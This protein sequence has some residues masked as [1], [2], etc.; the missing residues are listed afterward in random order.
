MGALTII[1]MPV[2]II[3]GKYAFRAL[4]DYT[5]QRKQGKDPVFRAKDISLPHK[6]DYRN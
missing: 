1:N 2:I 4:D 3:F 5:K 6:T